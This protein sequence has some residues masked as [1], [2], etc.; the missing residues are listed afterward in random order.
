MVKS[1]EW[2]TCRKGNPHGQH[3]H[4]YNA[5]DLY[6]GDSNSVSFSFCSKHLHVRCEF[7][8]MSMQYLNNQRRKRAIF[9]VNK[10]TV[11]RRSKYER[12]HGETWENHSKELQQTSQR[13][14]RFVVLVLLETCQQLAKLRLVPSV[15][16]IIFYSCNNL[17]LHH[18]CC[19]PPSPS[20]QIFPQHSSKVPWKS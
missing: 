10:K 14:S 8:I 5:I 13:A 18:T 7:Y 16:S 17:S 2:V 1:Y 4:D 6:W 20:F 15:A 19:L 11:L 12:V 9:I 3:A